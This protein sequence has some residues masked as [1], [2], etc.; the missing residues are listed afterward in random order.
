MGHSD[1]N[2][3]NPALEEI[4]PQGRSRP[5]PASATI[6]AC[7]GLLALMRG[8][9]R[10]AGSL[11]SKNSRPGCPALALMFTIP[12]GV[13][14]G[15]LRRALDRNQGRYLAYP[16]RAHEGKQGQRK[17]HDVPISAG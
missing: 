16:R 10:R 1:E 2:R 13:V 8:S 12:S 14:A 4:D 17:P 3:A 5:T 11:S 6:R 9:S 7:C 15:E